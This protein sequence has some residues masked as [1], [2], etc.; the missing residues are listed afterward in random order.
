MSAG[1]QQ[2]DAD[3]QLHT[4]EKSVMRRGDC[5]RTSEAG[6]EAQLRHDELPGQWSP[7]TASHMTQLTSRR[8]VGLTDLLMAAH[9]SQSQTLT[10]PVTTV[11]DSTVR[12]A[13]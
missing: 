8:C 5:T 4:V 9:K 7:L 12:P 11:I 10:T 3:A 6:H 2:C 1:C 13:L